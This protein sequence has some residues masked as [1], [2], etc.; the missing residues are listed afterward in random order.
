MSYSIEEAS[1]AYVVLSGIDI[2]DVS[3]DAYTIGAIFDNQR[4]GVVSRVT[5]LPEVSWFNRRAS[6]AILEIKYWYNNAASINFREKM[7]SNNREARIVY[8]DPLYWIATPTDLGAYF[9]YGTEFAA[10]MT[11]LEE[12]EWLLSS[13]QMLSMNQ[14]NTNND[15]NELRNVL[16]GIQY[17]GNNNIEINIYDVGEYCDA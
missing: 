3:I 11:I 6:K 15:W 17:E 16:D 13:N 1:S 9:C 12:P 2:S 14:F 4:L 8:N 10:F 5:I 7:L